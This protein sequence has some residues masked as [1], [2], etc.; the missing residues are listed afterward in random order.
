MKKIILSL[1]MLSAFATAQLSAEAKSYQLYAV[2]LTNLLQ[3]TLQSKH[4]QK[5]AY[6]A[7]LGLGAY[8]AP[9]GISTTQLDI[10]AE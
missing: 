1:A 8:M 3:N 7:F 4:V 6:I 9:G 10:T 2:W 5:C